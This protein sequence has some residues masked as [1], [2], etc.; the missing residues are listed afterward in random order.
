[1]KNVDREVLVKKNEGP[2][3]HFTPGKS[4]ETRT[5]RRVT[6]SHPFTH[7]WPRHYVGS[8][9][10]KCR[11]SHWCLRQAKDKRMRRA[12]A[13]R[14]EGD[15][16]VHS[17]SLS[18]L[19]PQTTP[20]HLSSSPTFT[21]LRRQTVRLLFMR[22]TDL[23]LGKPTKSARICM[24]RSHPAVGTL[25]AN[26]ARCCDQP[27][28]RADTTEARRKSSNFLFLYTCVFHGRQQ[29]VY[30]MDPMAM[31]MYLVIPTGWIGYF[32]PTHQDNQ[33]HTPKKKRAKQTAR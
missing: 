22:K 32:L 4:G 25:G 29:F 14:T 23:T 15:S 2:V 18:L 28:A 27:K 21:R 30:P 11:P 26:V 6:T 9:C 8:S 33:T 20:P 31:T 7:H 3:P 10:R 13:T 16:R 19:V 24:Q 5:G 1:M 12:Q 17:R